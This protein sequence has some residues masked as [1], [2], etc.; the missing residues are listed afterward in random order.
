MSISPKRLQELKDIPDDAIDTSDITELDESFW[1]KAKIVIPTTKKTIS[2]E[3]D[4]DVLDWFTSQGKD[5]QSLINSVL[6]SYIEHQQNPPK[7]ILR[8]RD[9]R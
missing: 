5:Y 6:R 9:N 8:K 4:S 3:I 2:L 1:K 7:R